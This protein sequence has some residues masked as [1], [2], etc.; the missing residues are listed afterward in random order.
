M[1]QFHQE[2]L[3]EV[4]NMQ[5]E[6]DSEWEQQL[7][8]LTEQFDGAQKKKDRAVSR[9]LLMYFKK[10]TLIQ[11]FLPRDALR[12]LRGIATVSRPSLRP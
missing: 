3:V 1:A 7:K 8:A 9:L 4:E 11:P 6:F 2:R 12:A 5:K 10:L